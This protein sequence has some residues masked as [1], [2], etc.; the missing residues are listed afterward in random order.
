[1]YQYTRSY[2]RPRGLNK[3]WVNVDVSLVPL[4]TLFDNYVDGYVVLNN[5]VI[6]G[7]P[8]YV[9]YHDLKQTALPFANLPFA[10]WLA[11]IGN[12]ALPYSSVEPNYIT[13]TA[14][15]S[16]AV[17]AMFTVTRVHPTIAPDHCVDLGLPLSSLTDLLLHK[18][19]ISFDELHQYALFTVNGLVHRSI[20]TDTGMQ[21]SKGGQSVDLCN[22]A[23]VGVISFKAIGE[24]QQIPITLNNIYGQTHVA[25]RYSVFVETGMDLR[26]HSV[27][28]SLGGYLH[29]CDHVVSVVSSDTGVVR[30]ELSRVDLVRRM[31]ES[32]QYIDL[33]TM[34][35][36]ESAIRIGAL[37]VGEVYPDAAI[38]AYLTLSQSF[39]IVVAA[40]NLHTTTIKL[41]PPTLPGVFECITEPQWPLRSPTG[42]LP[43]YWRKQ[44]HDRWILDSLL[45]VTKDALYATTPW[46]DGVVND[47][48]EHNTWRYTSATLLG[49]HSTVLIA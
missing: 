30:I 25:H 15:Y 5:N 46:S 39:L 32:K 41:A 2:L 6:S 35:V 14:L 24:I 12:V 18:D 26:N 4:A 11:W 44:E 17:Q 31:L 21:L 19:N 7:T 22:Q 8:L 34:P 42:R 37:V 1:M 20:P 10:T 28:L 23:H 13:H 3:T 38:D 16:D 45:S 27:M 48:V 29:V 49:I 33:S 40:P 43:E 36:T 47:T 9:N